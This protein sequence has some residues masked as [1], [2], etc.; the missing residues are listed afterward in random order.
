M[1]GQVNLSIIFINGNNSKDYSWDYRNP[2]NYEDKTYSADSSKPVSQKEL[3][4]ILDKISYHG[5]N[6]LTPEEHAML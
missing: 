3:D 6:S 1:Y 2:K 4:Q 5:I